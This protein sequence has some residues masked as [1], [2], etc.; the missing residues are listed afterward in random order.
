MKSN[1]KKL[2]S[3]LLALCMVLALCACGATE[4]AAP[5]EEAPAEE[6]IEEVVVEAGE[7]V[8]DEADFAE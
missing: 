3:L 4:E 1:M 6:V 5:A 8:A 2:L 7:P